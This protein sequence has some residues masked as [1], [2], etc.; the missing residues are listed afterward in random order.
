MTDLN[1]SFNKSVA[2]DAVSVFE[3]R[4]VCEV[5]QK[6]PVIGGGILM[7][8]YNFLPGR[9]DVT[10]T[11]IHENRTE[12]LGVKDIRELSPDTM[13]SVTNAFC[14]DFVPSMGKSGFPPFNR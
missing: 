1:D 10:G 14:S 7:R 4:S 9:I 6:T 2:P 11:F 13:Q 8:V 12:E 5:I 3:K